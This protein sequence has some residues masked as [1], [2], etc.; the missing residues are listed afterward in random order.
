M[1]K[2]VHTLLT[3][4]LAGHKFPGGAEQHAKGEY[5]VC[6]CSN[7]CQFAPWSLHD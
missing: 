5:P 6:F 1:K 2:I 3:M 7:R 4:G